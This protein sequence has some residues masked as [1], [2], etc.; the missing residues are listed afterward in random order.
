M[1]MTDPFWFK[2]NEI[3]FSKS[4]LF[5]FWPSKFQS[6]E[7]RINA[8]T[9]FILYAGLILS[10][11]NKNTSPLTMAGLLI[12]IIVILSK[13]KN[14]VLRRVLSKSEEHSDCQKPSI[15]NPL[16]NQIPFDDTYRKPGCK[17]SSV[18][19]EITKKLFAEFPTN[20]LSTTNQNFIER[21]FFSTANTD[22][23]NNQKGF[24][25]WLYGAPNKKM[26]KSNPEH[27]TGQ[28]GMQN[29]GNSSGNPSGP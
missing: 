18:E 5:Q 20:G 21:Q 14:P 22:I 29:G 4:N 17:S 16:G 7:E 24:A 28:Q 6:H 12:F 27:C 9:R 25:S 1:Y 10:F 3:L 8:I 13:S 15:T 26:C 11:R 2:K 19:G 23:V